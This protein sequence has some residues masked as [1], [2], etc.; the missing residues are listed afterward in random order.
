V[1]HTLPIKLLEEALHARRRDL[2]CLALLL[3]SA[4][5]VPSAATRPVASA[6]PP[7]R[8]A[9]RLVAIPAP[10]EPEPMLL[11]PV[12]PTDAAA[13]NASIP[14]AG[15]VGPSAGAFAFRG[16]APIDRLRSLQCLSE[17]VYYEARSES[18]DGQRAVAQ[19]V[20]N[21]V[22]HPAYPGSVCGVVYQ[23]PMRAG[24]GC[25]F[26][27]TCDGSLALPPS[28]PAWLAARRIAAEALA[29]KAYAPVGLATHYHTQQ[30]VPVW[31]FR[32]TK[33]AVIGNHIFYRTPGTWGTPAAFRQS[34]AGREPS[35]ATIIANRLPIS[36]GRTAS[37][38]LLP[39]APLPL[40]G[41]GPSAPAEA[42][43]PPAPP[44]DDRLPV[45]NVKPEF[46]TSGRWLAQPG[47]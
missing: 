3:G 31:A 1:L 47:N 44:V 29:G 24:G 26:T 23:G 20:L 7:A 42:T 33:A 34:Y 16:S 5:C 17:A 18:E 36:L 25:Q 46:E 30:V 4:S 40:G 37:A 41:Y 43:A 15:E 2:A 14:L 35:P 11:Q 21:R 22:R 38:T 27:F 28:G 39:A 10:P 12:S 8:V 45:S 32:L 6:A 9:E 13:I 19:V